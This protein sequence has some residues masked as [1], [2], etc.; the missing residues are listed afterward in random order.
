M[1]ML[2]KSPKVCLPFPENDFVFVEKFGILKLWT[3]IPWLRRF[4]L[5]FWQTSNW[6]YR[7]LKDSEKTF[8]QF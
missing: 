5:G 6:I 2:L 1:K 4:D 7:K 3:N 8:G